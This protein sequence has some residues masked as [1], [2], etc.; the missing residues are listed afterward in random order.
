MQTATSAKISPEML[1]LLA[2]HRGITRKI[3]S[4]HKEARLIEDQIKTT[5]DR[6]RAQLRGNVVKVDGR[7]ISGALRAL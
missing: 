3:F 2:K 1:N 6:E 4:L 7:G 5:E